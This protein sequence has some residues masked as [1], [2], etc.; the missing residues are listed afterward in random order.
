MRNSQGLVSIIIPVYNC[1]DLMRRC[2]QSILN[3]TYQNVECI[4]V[5]DGSTDA[6]VQ[7]CDELSAQN[8]RVIALHKIN[9]GAERAREF[10]VE[11]CNGDFVMFVDADDYIE[12]DIVQHCVAQMEKT[13]ANI[14]CFDYFLGEKGKKGFGI[15]Q[16]EEIDS[17][18]A[19]QYMFLLH[20]LDGNMWCKLYTRKLLEGVRFDTRRNCDFVTIANVLER[21]EKIVVVPIRGYH[22]S[23]VEGSQSRNRVCHPK[24]EE[25]ENAAYELFCK[26]KGIYPLVGNAAKYYWLLALLYVCIQMEKDISLQ[27]RLKR[28]KEYKCKFRKHAKEFLTN[29]YMSEAHKIRYI[30]CYTN[31][32]RILSIGIRWVKVRK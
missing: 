30:L 9:E 3:Q 20:C 25:Y 16:T 19:L 1:A 32:F 31:M 14:V 23:V 13:G 22:Y 29:S 26:Y 24:E 8:G 5:D 18:T 4:I 15:E 10:G 21:A 28:F 6:T 2:V 12:P 11:R 17:V 7:V 27:R